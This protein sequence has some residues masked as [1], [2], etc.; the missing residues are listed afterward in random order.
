MEKIPKIMKSVEK[1]LNVK[2]DSP[3][4]SQEYYCMSKTI[5]KSVVIMLVISVMWI[6]K[7]L[8]YP[9]F[10]FK[11]KFRF[12]GSFLNWCVS[13]EKFGFKIVMVFSTVFKILT[14]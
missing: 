5:L 10:T 2:N 11:C 12:R 1:L 14:Q 8:L 13:E 4:P 9:I 7:I 3:I 6:K